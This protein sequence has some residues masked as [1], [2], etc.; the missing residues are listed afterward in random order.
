IA[1]SDD[2]AATGNIK[3]RQMLQQC[4]ALPLFVGETLPRRSHGRI[5]IVRGSRRVLRTL[6]TMTGFWDGPTKPSS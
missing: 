4:H 1:V 2:L 5:G 6:L 3:L